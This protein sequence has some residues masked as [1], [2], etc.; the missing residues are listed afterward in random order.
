MA[1]SGLLDKVPCMANADRSYGP[2]LL[3]A[4][5]AQDGIER[6]ATFID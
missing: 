2:R 5:E 1:V 6:P 4:N 3:Y